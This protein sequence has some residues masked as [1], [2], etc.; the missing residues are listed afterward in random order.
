MQKC[1]QADRLS[2]CPLIPNLTVPVQSWKVDIKLQACR[3]MELEKI[4]Y[5]LIYFKLYAKLFVYLYQPYSRS[6]KSG[7][8]VYL[9]STTHVLANRR[10]LLNVTV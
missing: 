9:N 10:V 6:T 2:A 4:A 3:L 5:L 7:K 1:Q 8:D